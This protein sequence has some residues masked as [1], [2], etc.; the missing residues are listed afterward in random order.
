MLEDDVT[1]HRD[2]LA[3][4]P[5]YMGGLGEPPVFSFVY[6]GQKSLAISDANPLAQPSAIL[7]LLA[8][9][10]AP[11]LLHAYLVSREMAAFLSRHLHGLLA[12]AGSRHS[13]A[14]PLPKRAPW[15]LDPSDI[16]VDFYTKDVIHRGFFRNQPRL[17]GEGGA[18]LPQWAAFQS[19]AE[20]PAALGP[21]R[22]WVKNGDVQLGS[23]HSTPEECWRWSGGC[24]WVD[25]ARTSAC[26]FASGRLPIAGTGLAFQNLCVEAG[27]PFLLRVWT[28]E[29]AAEAVPTCAQLRARI[30]PS[31]DSDPSPEDCHDEGTAYSRSATPSPAPLPA[32]WSQHVSKSTGRTFWY[33][34]STGVSTY[35]RP[36]A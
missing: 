2:F 30:A 29:A 12:R 33:H 9:K 11:W 22:T 4:W 15:A 1:F 34:A 26:G 3:L 16:N 20:V 19:T 35:D 18:F 27:R 17:R 23:R 5:R 28:G 32:A 21:N 7:E 13:R 24:T 14:E 31:A 25:E 6:V 36:R 10:E 8:D